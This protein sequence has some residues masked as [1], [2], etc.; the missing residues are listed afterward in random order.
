VLH[1]VNT[2][3]NSYG[4]KMEKPYSCVDIEIKV[5]KPRIF[6]IFNSVLRIRISD[7]V[8]FR[9]RDPGWGKN[10]DPGSTSQII[11]PRA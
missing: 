5:L 3:P 8:L 11:L 7:P 9:P 10:P 6:G 1:I 4:K 2:A